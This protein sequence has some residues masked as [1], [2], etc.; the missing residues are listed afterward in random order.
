MPCYPLSVY[1]FVMLIT[2][3]TWE[4][5]MPIFVFYFHHFLACSSTF[6]SLKAVWNVDINYVP[7]SVESSR[8]VLELFVRCFD[9]VA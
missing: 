2:G 8:A 4:E 5:T 1:E 6:A 7:L 9:S 3:Y